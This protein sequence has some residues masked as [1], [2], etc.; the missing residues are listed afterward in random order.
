MSG[1]AK[2]M[3]YV[4]IHGRVQGVG[5]RAWTEL[6]ARARG[7]DG[8]VRNCRDGTV[9]AVFLGPADKVTDMTEACRHGPAGARVERVEERDAH[10]DDLALR[11]FNE[12]FSVLKTR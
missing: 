5:F 3:R 1:T 4:L 6:G 12:A 10:A 7:L 9:E 8:W 2:S 11:R